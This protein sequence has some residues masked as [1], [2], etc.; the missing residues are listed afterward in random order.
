M[1]E[2]LNRQK[3]KKREYKKVN[4]QLDDQAIHF[5]I[6]LN[7]MRPDLLKQ[8][9]KNSQPDPNK[10]ED[11]KKQAKCV[12]ASKKQPAEREQAVAQEVKVDRKDIRTMDSKDVQ[13]IVREILNEKG[14]LKKGKTIIYDKFTDPN[15]KD[16]DP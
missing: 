1:N 15:Y 16:S 14:I 9:K 8:F 13:Q 11:P 7:K 3:Q 4:S 6:M 12:S 2:H 10:N 5:E